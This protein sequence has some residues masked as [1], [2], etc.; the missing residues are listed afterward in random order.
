MSFIVVHAAGNAPAIEGEA[1]EEQGQEQNE[2]H[3]GEP[4][5]AKKQHE[6][7]IHQKGGKPA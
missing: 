7:S 1:A 4:Q 2:Q 6:G 5:E 3:L